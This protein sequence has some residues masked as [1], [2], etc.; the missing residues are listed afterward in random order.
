MNKRKIALAM[1]GVTI[2]GAFTG[3]AE[4][5]A[6]TPDVDTEV[7]Q[8]KD[9]ND[10]KTNQGKTKESPVKVEDIE[11]VDFSIEDDG[12]G[13][14]ELKTKFKNNS[15]ET[16]VYV[17]YVYSIN[18]EKINIT[19]YDTLLP[20]DVSTFEYRYLE[21]Y[22]KDEDELKLLQV[23]FDISKGDKT[24]YVSYDAKLDK[25]TVDEH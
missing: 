15:K 1:L 19:T 22:N 12:Y 16:L 6:V 13:E 8:E 11:L 18:D 17:E 24:T 4:K 5:D 9:K 2:L 10:S 23:N 25:Y 21:E 7:S 14:Y 20:D 3:C